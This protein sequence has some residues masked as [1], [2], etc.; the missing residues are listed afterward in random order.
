M[1]R[2]LVI[3][4][5]AYRGAVEEQYGHLPWICWSHDRMGG[6]IG[7]LLRGNAVFYACRDQREL[8]LTLGGMTLPN[9][10]DYAASIEGLLADGRPV[11]VIDSD[12]ARLQ[13]QPGALRPGIERLDERDL[14]RLFSEYDAVWY[15]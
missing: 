10:Y 5:R 7:V 9:L 3:I 14:T 6:D 1:R 15:W 12:L 2:F 13:L 8:S 11:Y 4:E